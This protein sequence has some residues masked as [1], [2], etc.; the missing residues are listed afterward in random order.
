MLIFVAYYTSS[1]KLLGFFPRLLLLSLLRSCLC[2]HPYSTK[3]LQ[4]PLG[5]RA[6]A[7][8]VGCVFLLGYLH[9]LLPGRLTLQMSACKG[10]QGVP[11]TSF[12]H[13]CCMNLNMYS[14]RAPET[15]SR[16]KKKK[17]GFVFFWGGSTR[18]SSRASV[19]WKVC[20]WSP[21]HETQGWS[22]IT[23][24]EHPVFFL[25]NKLVY[26]G[27]YINSR[28]NLQVLCLFSGL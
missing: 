6:G 5:G 13:W 4:A 19:L 14:E 1:S 25:R 9:S 7:L 28:G 15:E 21:H 22:V 16:K 10:P 27:D 26:L 23:W 8:V 12:L 24:T 2:L 11:V 17:V 3:G 18:E 20:L